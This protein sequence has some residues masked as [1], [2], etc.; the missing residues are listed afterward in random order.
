MADN[1]I[2]IESSP[3]QQSLESSETNS[4]PA[5]DPLVT[6][7]TSLFQDSSPTP[8]PYTEQP[9]EPQPEQP[10]QPA[11]IINRNILRRIIDS[12]RKCVSNRK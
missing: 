4:S 10:Q 8:P 3:V 5:T 12:I 7:I 2:P 9:Q 6:H 11:P 1:H